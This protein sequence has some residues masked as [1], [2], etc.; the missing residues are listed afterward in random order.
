MPLNIKE[1]FDQ[2]CS[3]AKLV[4]ANLVFVKDDKVIEKCHYGYRDLAKKEETSDKTIYRIASISKTIG[5]IGLM[6]LY[7]KGLFDLDGD[8]SDILGFEVRNPKYPDDIITPKMIMTQT[9]S[10]VDGYDDED[11][12]NNDIIKGYNGVNGSNLEVS[13]KDLLTNPNSQYYT[14]KTFSDYR[15]GERFIYSNFGC[16]I[17]ACMIEKLSGEYFTDY[18]INHVFKPLGIDGSFV[19]TD[20][21]RKENI[22]STYLPS[23]D[24]YV[25]SRSREG[26]LSSSY[27]KWP[28]GDNFRGPAGGLFIDMD[29]LSRLMR[30]FINGGEVDGV[31]LLKKETVDLMY[32]IHWIGVGG[33]SY[34]SKGLQMK[35]METFLDQDVI[36]RGHTGG[37]YGVRSYMF[38]NQK[39]NLGAI[40]ITNGGYYKKDNE[41][42]LLDVFY[43]TL[44]L[45]IDEYYPKHKES[46]FTFCVGSNVSN[47]DNRTIIFDKEPFEYDGEV[48]VPFYNFCDG[49]ETVGEK[50]EESDVIII[51]KNGKEIKTFSPTRFD[52]V[53]MI[54]LFKTLDAL[55]MKY[56]K[57]NEK[58]EISY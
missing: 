56:T 10:I 5:A 7:E 17:M 41:H 8:I 39:Y 25:I 12:K 42:N 34:R 24:G 19:S 32:Q 31:R 58:I 3:S 30:M 37:A 2:I 29:D 49:I 27:K 47:V 54:P 14:D 15:P 33:D 18:M 23:D 9:S 20:I 35:V 4:G 38:F 22:A 40:F 16:G 57:D 46:H 36:F 13:L 11:P 44:K 1:K 45:F 48:F 51:K 26:F 21:R 43:E 6:Q 28:L 55:N 50:I 52:G 53:I